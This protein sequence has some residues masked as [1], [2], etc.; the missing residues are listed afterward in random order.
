M[1]HNK[2]LKIEER[3]NKL[4]ELKLELLAS[5]EEEQYQ[6]DLRVWKSFLDP[7][8]EPGFVDKSYAERQF[9]MRRWLALFDYLGLNFEDLSHGGRVRISCE[10]MH[11]LLFAIDPLKR[12][13]NRIAA[14]HSVK[15]DD[16]TGKL[17]EVKLAKKSDLVD[18]LTRMEFKEGVDKIIDH[19][20]AALISPEHW[21]I[22]LGLCADEEAAPANGSF[23]HLYFNVK[24]HIEKIDGK[25]V[26]IWSLLIG[27]EGAAPNHISQFKV[28]H[29]AK[30]EQAELSATGALK[31]ENGPRIKEF[32]H[33][34][35]VKTAI[36]FIEMNSKMPLRKEEKFYRYENNLDDENKRL[37]EIQKNNKLNC[38]VSYNGYNLKL[39]AS[40]NHLID[41]Y[42][43]QLI[44]AGSDEKKLTSIITTIS[45]ELDKR[46][47]TPNEYNNKFAVQ[48]LTT[49]VSDPRNPKNEPIKI[50]SLITIFKDEKLR[51]AF[52]KE[53]VTQQNIS[54]QPFATRN[55]PGD[56]NIAAH[57]RGT[58]KDSEENV[59]S[60]PISNTNQPTKR[61][62]RYGVNLS[63]IENFNIF[64]HGNEEQ[65]KIKGQVKNPNDD[66]KQTPHK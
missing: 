50:G 30:A 34:K 37:E 57:K 22:N 59:K 36:K 4:T 65:V 39:N 13:E 21:C 48:I 41:S 51:Q 14:T 20:N 53:P 5:S 61:S 44:K 29:N 54:A 66:H 19:S 35:D 10:D 43:A 58:S 64:T 16:K 24:K 26:E 11:D 18:A 31:N 23:G 2:S 28:E 8:A 63:Q 56:T 32:I 33:I 55:I 17:Q 25:D 42:Q 1:Q 15:D 62:N 46:I 12:C 27:I 49:S 52:L 7:D 60:E 45:A 3:I 9:I 6:H 40:D 38:T 47:K